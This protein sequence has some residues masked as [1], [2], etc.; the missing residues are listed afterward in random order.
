MMFS[1]TFPQ[2]C[3]QMAAD[4]LYEHLFIGVGVVGGAARTVSQTLLK[5]APQDKCDK[6]IEFIDDFLE[7]RKEGERLLVFTNSKQ[8]AKGLDEKL[9][10]LN[11]DTGALHG[12][13]KQ[14]QR[15][16]NL[17]QF[18]DGDI[19][20]MIATDV[21]SRGLDISG[22]SQVLNYDLPFNIDCYVQRI[23]RTGR[24][25]N[26]GASTTFIA[27]DQD[28]TWQDSSPEQQECLRAIPN[29]MRDAGLEN[30]IPDWL[31]SKVTE[32]DSAASAWSSR[33]NRVDMRQAP[34]LS[35][36]DNW[37]A[38]V[39]APSVNNWAA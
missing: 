21:A 33:A 25:G 2:E 19:D 37:S 17:K 6:L 1:A 23:G 12:D 38:Q 22:V 32:L 36:A 3:Q 39:A 10:E 29:V 7:K 24:I 35:A 16:K 11:M 30:S 26:R 14:D 28:G 27:V 8:Q 31:L 20:V 13:L 15:E 4:Y 9:Y 5:V 34:G 18:R